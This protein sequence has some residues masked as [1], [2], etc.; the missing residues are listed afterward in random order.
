MEMQRMTSERIQETFLRLVRLDNPSGQETPVVDWL[1]GELEA[2]EM[3]IEQDDALNLLARLPGEGEPL[4]LNA[5]TDSVQ[6]CVGVQPVVSDGIVSSSGDTVLGADDLAGVTAILEGV[7]RAVEAG[8]PHRAVEL[9]FTS[10]EEIGLQGAK[11][12]DYSRLNARDAVL[13]DSTGSIGGIC[14]G[15]P[16]QASLSASVH[17]KAAHAG[18]APEEGINAIQVAAEAITRMPLGRIDEE[19]TANIGVI[20]GGEATNIVTP[21]VELRGETRSHDPAKLE[22]QVSAMRSALEAAAERYQAQVD[23]NLSYP[24]RA[25]HLHEGEPLVQYIMKAFRCLNIEPYTFISGGGS[26]ANIF[27]ANGLHVVNLSINYQDIHTVN[28][29]IALAD[30]EQAARLVTLLLE[31]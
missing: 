16:S 12:F 5:H 15:S 18:I 25:Y 13:F 27:A 10:Q 8:K 7:R 31:T 17:G 1:R 14:L 20:H 23:I 9:L 30:L 26:D 29:H 28:E 24:Y 21:L 11:V 2:L 4:L 6:P 3:Q 22:A 19:T